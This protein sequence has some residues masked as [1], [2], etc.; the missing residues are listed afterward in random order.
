MSKQEIRDGELQL[1]AR[2]FADDF[3]SAANKVHG[4]NGSYMSFAMRDMLEAKLL[5]LLKDLEA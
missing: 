3:R 1:R 4:G 5:E 2:A